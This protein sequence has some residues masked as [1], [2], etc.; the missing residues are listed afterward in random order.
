M[1]QQ[2]TCC[3]GKKCAYHKSE[4]TVSKP[5]VLTICGKV[6]SALPREFFVFQLVHMPFASMCSWAS[7]HG[8]SATGRPHMSFR[9]LQNLE[10]Q[11]LHLY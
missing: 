11:S 6:S 8:I 1:T 2:L 5:H 4:T 3:H 10:I 7:C 9:D